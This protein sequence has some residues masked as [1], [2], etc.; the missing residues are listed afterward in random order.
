MPHITST[1]AAEY[2]LSDPASTAA[3][4]GS[5]SAAVAADAASALR[6]V[7]LATRFSIEPTRLAWTAVRD[8]W[9]APQPRQGLRSILGNVNIVEQACHRLSQGCADLAAA[10]SRAQADVRMAYTSADGVIAS[11]GLAFSVWSGGIDAMLRIESGRSALV[12][13]LNAAI[14]AIART[15]ESAATAACAQLATN[16]SAAVPQVGRSPAQRRNDD[17][18]AKLRTDLRGAP[19]RQEYFA[20]AI[21]AALARAAARGYRAQVLDY[22]SS[23]PSNQ[24]SVAI[25]LGDISMATF[26]TVLVPGV[27]NSPADIAGLFEPAH[28][29]NVATEAAAGAG[30]H[31]ATI[32]WLGYD[33]PLSWSSDGAMDSWSG[34]AGRAI[35]DSVAAIDAAGASTGGDLLASFVKTLRPLTSSAAS[36]TL[37]GHSYGATTVSQAAKVL[38]GRDGVDDVVLLAAPGAGYGVTDAGDYTAVG[39]DHVYSLSFANDPIPGIGQSSLIAALNPISQNIRKKVLGSDPGPFGPNP[40]TAKF[41]ANII[42]APSN[43]PGDRKFDFDQHALSNYLSGPSLDGIAAVT[44]TRYGQV[45]VRAPV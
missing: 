23:F 14:Q 31:A 39:P 42:D 25:A 11:M 45:P 41:G 32:V 37:V 6:S 35:T 40:S 30:S 8:G 44:A 1:W 36:I 29:L 19:G 7:T 33:V 27:G 18:V 26:I 38:G 9:S 10:I 12:R 34:S 2:G 24:G 5:A 28:A 4:I 15:L 3:E 21:A 20:S 22:D 17:N 43:V 16:P 13:N